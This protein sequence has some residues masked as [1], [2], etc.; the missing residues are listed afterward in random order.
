MVCCL[1]Q[2]GMVKLEVQGLWYK[3]TNGGHASPCGRFG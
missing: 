3:G 2:S 1:K